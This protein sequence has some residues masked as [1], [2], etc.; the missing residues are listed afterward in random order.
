MG[1]KVDILVQV[2][3]GTGVY[4]YDGIVRVMYP[5]AKRLPIDAC[6]EVKRFIDSNVARTRDKPVAIVT[7]SQ[8][9]CMFV[10]GYAGKKGYSVKF[11]YGDGKKAIGFESLMG[12]FNR[13]FRYMDRCSGAG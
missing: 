3:S 6:R 2:P 11:Y 1:K 12:K 5:E 9:V 13:V 10:D 4:Y 8:E 7:V